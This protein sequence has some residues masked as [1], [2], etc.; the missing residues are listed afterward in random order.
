M[1]TESKI[2]QLYNDALDTRDRMERENVTLDPAQVEAQH[3][4]NVLARVLEL[5]SIKCTTR[6][7]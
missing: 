2:K 5:D 6:V 7:P 3:T 4:I 1:L